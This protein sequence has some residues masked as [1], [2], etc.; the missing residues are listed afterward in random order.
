MLLTHTSEKLKIRLISFE[1]D[2]G[3][4]LLDMLFHL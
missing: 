2:Y 3:V 4:S 1:D